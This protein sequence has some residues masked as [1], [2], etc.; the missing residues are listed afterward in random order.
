MLLGTFIYSPASAAGETDAAVEAWLR[1]VD[2][3]QLQGILERTLPQDRGPIMWRSNNNNVVNRR[4]VRWDT[5]HPRGIF[6][7]GFLPWIELDSVIEN[8]TDPALNLDLFV[9]NNIPSVYVST[10]QVRPNGGVWTPRD[11]ANSFRYDI[12]APGGIDVNPTLAPHPFENQDEVA[13]VG[14]IHSRLI[15]GALE[16][17]ESRRQ[18]MYHV[19]PHFPGDTPTNAPRHPRTPHTTDN[20]IPAPSQLFCSN[21]SDSFDPNSDTCGNSMKRSTTTDNTNC[22]ELMRSD[23][24]IEASCS[25]CFEVHVS[26]IKFWQSDEL[27]QIEPYGEIYAYLDSMERSVIL[28]KVDG[29]S[30]AVPGVDQGSPQAKQCVVLRRESGDDSNNVCFGGCV[31]ESDGGFSD[32]EVLTNFVMPPSCI[33]TSPQTDPSRIYNYTSTDS[34]DGKVE[35]DFKVQLCSNCS[36][37]ALKCSGRGMSPGNVSYITVVIM[38]ACLLHY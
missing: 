19:N 12:F 38:F 4:L 37:N 17:D 16:L 32:D 25:H 23:E 33:S 20:S 26:A 1:F 35:I 22:N 7:T 14:G 15:Y 24:D 11:R 36:S 21:P 18:V 30:T 2:I 6:H 34:P 8:P 29:S 27:G 31:K 13:F 9:R 28:W 10:A 3:T 5:R